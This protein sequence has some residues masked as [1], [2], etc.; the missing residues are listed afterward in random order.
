VRRGKEE[1]T[2]GPKGQM[3][4]LVYVRA[5]A[6]TYLSRSAAFRAVPLREVMYGLEPVHTFPCPAAF[7][8]VPMERGYVRAGARTLQKPPSI[9]SGIEGDGL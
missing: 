4:L 1:R 6:R 7:I 8:A 3:T 9:M 5:K 2:S